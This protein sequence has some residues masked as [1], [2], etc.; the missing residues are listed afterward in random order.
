MAAKL[1]Q[2][3]Q[4]SAYGGGVSGL[5]V[6]SSSSFFFTLFFEFELT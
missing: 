4:Y 3:V 5:K 6:R 1:M 2:A